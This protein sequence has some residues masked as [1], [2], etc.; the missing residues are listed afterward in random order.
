MNSLLAYFT[1]YI[2]FPNMSNP[3]LLF[4][5]V[6]VSLQVNKKEQNKLPDQT[7]FYFRTCLLLHCN[8]QEQLWSYRIFMRFSIVFPSKNQVHT[9]QNMLKRKTNDHSTKQPLTKLASSHFFSFSRV[10]FFSF[11]FSRIPFFSKCSGKEQA[12]ITVVAPCQVGFT[13][14]SGHEGGTKS[15]AWTWVSSSMKREKTLLVNSNSAFYSAVRLEMQ[16]WWKWKSLGRESV[17]SAART[18]Q[19]LSKKNFS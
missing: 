3:V 9:K 16:T 10:P 12:L 19:E 1:L 4:Q 2:H 11:S 6:W 5:W 8:S 13:G 15:E 14:R 18:V 7:C 17:R